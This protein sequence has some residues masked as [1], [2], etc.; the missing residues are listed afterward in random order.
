[1]L[2]RAKGILP[3]VK[4]GDNVLIPIPSVDRGRADPPN[5][6]GVVLEIQEGKFRVAVKDGNMQTFVLYILLFLP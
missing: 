3:P 2:T 1:M 4:V 6:I 5:L